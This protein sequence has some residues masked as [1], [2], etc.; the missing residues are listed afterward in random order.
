MPSCRF[1]MLLFFVLTIL[2]LVLLQT[3]RVLK[4]RGM[5]MGQILALVG[6]RSHGDEL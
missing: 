2:L 4:R 6:L 5:S 1:M 3:V